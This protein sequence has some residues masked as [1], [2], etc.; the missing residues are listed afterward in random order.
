M[1]VHY[2]PNEFLALRF[3]QEELFVGY[4]V[5]QK[6]YAKQPTDELAKM[7]KAMESKLFPKPKLVLVGNKHLCTN[8]LQELD[9][10]VD[11]YQVNSDINGVITWR[12]QKCEKLPPLNEPPEVY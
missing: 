6:I 9:V 5:L 1:H 8:C 12:H 3:S 11:K 10:R 7:I 4:D 2:R